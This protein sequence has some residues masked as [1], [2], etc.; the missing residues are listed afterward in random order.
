MEVIFVIF[1]DFGIQI[2]H[3]L[4]DWCPFCR[5]IISALMIQEASINGE[6]IVCHSCMNAFEP[7]VREV[8]GDSRNQ[9][10]IIHKDGWNIFS[11]SWLQ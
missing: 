7:I 10:T 5:E 6:A 9:V 8:A 4:P 1:H 11:I 2:K 3:I